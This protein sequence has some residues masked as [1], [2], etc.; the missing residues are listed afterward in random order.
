MSTKVGVENY[1]SIDD[2]QVSKIIEKNNRFQA[3]Q[4]LILV[5]QDIVKRRDSKNDSNF[6][7]F[8]L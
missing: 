6:Y 4:T 1:E 7:E 5:I 8:S 2:G 3:S